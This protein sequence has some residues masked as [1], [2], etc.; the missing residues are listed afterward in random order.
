MGLSAPLPHL[1][2]DEGAR[3]QP[4]HIR[5]DRHLADAAAVIGARTFS[6]TWDLHCAVITCARQ[7]A[8]RVLLREVS[9]NAVVFDTRRRTSDVP[10]HAV[11]AL[12]LRSAR[13]YTLEV[14]VWSSVAGPLR[15]AIQLH[16]A[17]LDEWGGEWIGGFTQLRGEFV[18]AQPKNAIA[19][20]LAEGRGKR[21]CKHPR[22][23][24]Q[25]IW[26]LPPARCG[27]KTNWQCGPGTLALC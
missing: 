3:L 15:S 22:G 11:T 23:S 25:Q 10:M 8:Y 27:G 13:A 5:I 2:F 14:S 20:A 16:T 21:K 12:E 17:L 26:V 9:S 24:P 6:V 7:R 1:A 19:S 4:S 18:L